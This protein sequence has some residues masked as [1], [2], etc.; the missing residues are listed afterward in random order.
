MSTEQRKGVVDIFKIL[1]FI[2]LSIS[3]F[4]IAKKYDEQHEDIKAMRSE[5]KE[6]IKNISDKIQNIESRTI[7]M[8]YELKL[9]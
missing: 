8:E 7:R 1:M 5:V 9:K 6:D 4:L 3:G 2:S